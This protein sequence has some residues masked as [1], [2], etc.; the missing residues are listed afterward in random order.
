MRRFG[1][2]LAWVWILGA[3]LGMAAEGR[4]LLVTVDDLPISSGALHPDPDDRKAITRE[5]LAALDGHGIRA[6][7]MVT[8][9]NVR[10]SADLELLE[11]WLEA[12]HEL[13]NHSFGHLDYTRTETGEYIEDVERA[14]RELAG[15]LEARGRTLRFF[16]FPMLHEGET[17]E[18]LGAMRAYLEETGQRNLPVTIDNTDWTFERPWMEALRADDRQAMQEIG[19]DFNAA[20]RIAVRH[21]ERS[22]EELL[23]RRTPQILLLHATAVGT[24]QWDR[25]FSWLARNDHRFATADEV[26]RDPA[27][28]D[29]HAFV[30]PWGFSLWDRLAHERRAERARQEIDVLLQTQARAWS[31]GELEAFCSVYSDDALFVSPTGLTHGREEILQRYRRRYEDRAA[32]GLLT[33]EIVRFQPAA[34]VETSLLGDARPSRVHGASVVARWT[35]S[36]AD[37]DAASGLTLLVLRP[38]AGGWRIVQDASM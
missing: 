22:G 14:R 16:R 19:D 38:S 36:Y 35:L 37:R 25:L 20:L 33:L 1:A 27:F 23:G 34:G 30:G 3:G 12:G 17:A 7:G 29:P 9:R 2:V 28:S 32:M 5:M 24:A 8:W 6:V 15:F 10:S 18:K 11:M 31:N 4:P 26:L 13:G 21:H